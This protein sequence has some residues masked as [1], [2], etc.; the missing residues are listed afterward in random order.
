MWVIFN[1]HMNWIQTHFFIYKKEVLTTEI[2]CFPTIQ[3][4][5]HYFYRYFLKEAEQQQ[6]DLKGRSLE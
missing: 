3:I 5:K 4:L 6:K 2:W 1:L